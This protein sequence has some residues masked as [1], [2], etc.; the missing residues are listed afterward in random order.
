MARRPN[1]AVNLVPNVN[2]ISAFPSLVL[3]GMNVKHLQ[4]FPSAARVWETSVLR[5]SVLKSKTDGN[6]YQIEIIFE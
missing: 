5:T 3:K 6:I 4:G 1:A 2:L